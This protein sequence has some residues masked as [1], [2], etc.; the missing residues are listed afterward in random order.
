MGKVERKMPKEVLYSQ[1]ARYYDK[2]YWWKDY[3]REVS[4]L[5]GAFRKYGVEVRKLLEVASGTGNHTKILTRLG[6]DVTGVDISDDVL[7]IAR[8]KVP[9]GATFIR[10]DMRNLGTFVEGEFDAV[11]CMFSAI[12][13]NVGIPDLLRTLNGFYGRLRHG[14]IVVFDTH[15]T[16]KGFIN[17]YRG[18]DIFDEGNVI[19]A[20]LGTSSRRGGIG[21]INFTYLIKDKKKIIVIRNDIH[22]LGLFDPTDIIRVMRDVGF[23]RNKMYKD[24]TLKRRKKPKGGENIFVGIKP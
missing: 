8:K 24:W 12:S 1:L 15:F 5:T 3:E 23:I 7:R 16:K 22:K 4:F 10:G 2:I 14:G 21:K 11:V 18:E 17:R 13:Y 20:R 19:G 9:S 6:Y